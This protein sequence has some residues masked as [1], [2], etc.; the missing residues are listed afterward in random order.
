MRERM[1]ENERERNLSITVFISISSQL[2]G[3]D[4]ITGSLNQV[5]KL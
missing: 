5:F 4:Y 1:R 2:L 3:V